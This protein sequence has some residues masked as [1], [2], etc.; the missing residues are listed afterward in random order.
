M[1]NWKL[2]RLD[3]CKTD[4][5]NVMSCEYLNSVFVYSSIILDKLLADNQTSV[6]CK[7]EADNQDWFLSNFSFSCVQPLNMILW[8]HVIFTHVLDF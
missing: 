7:M 4:W 3:Y 6:S 5:S 2:V 1:E 8:P